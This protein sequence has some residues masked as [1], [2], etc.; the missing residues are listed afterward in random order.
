MQE[1]CKVAFLFKIRFN[2]KLGL[3]FLRDFSCPEFCVY[4][5]LNSAV[6]QFGMSHERNCTLYSFMKDCGSKFSWTFDTNAPKA[7]V[8]KM[9]FM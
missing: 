6:A 5:F 7:K 8:D 9:R 1:L 2:S 3:V 4:Q